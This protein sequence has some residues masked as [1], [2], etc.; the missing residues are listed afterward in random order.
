M[1]I[2]QLRLQCILPRQS[3]FPNCELPSQ[4]HRDGQA[5]RETEKDRDRNKQAD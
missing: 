1:T 3:L 4:K 2:A 5:D